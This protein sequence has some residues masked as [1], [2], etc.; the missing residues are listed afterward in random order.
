MDP[1]LFGQ[2]FSP[3]SVK[4]L[5][6]IT[7]LERERT[8]SDFEDTRELGFLADTEV[9]LTCWGAPPLDEVILD[10]AP[11]LRALVHAAGS[12]KEI[13]TDECWTRG[14]SVSS[15][16]WANARPVAEYTLGA[17][18]L[19]NKRLLELRERYAA[20]R[21]RWSRDQLPL[22]VGNYGRTIGIVGAS[23]V[24]RRLIELLRP[25]GFEILLCDPYVT[26]SE[27]SSLGVRLADLDELCMTSDVVSLHAP[28]LPATRHMIDGRRLGLLRDGATFINT[29]RGSLVDTEAL[30]DVLA[31]G[32]LYAVLDTTEPEVLP[33]D[34]PL[35]ELPNVV[36]TP[37][38]AGAVGNELRLLGDAALEELTRYASGASFAH[39]VLRQYLDRTA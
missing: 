3:A 11:N 29:A 7:Q 34:S 8:L 39:P 23:H 4:V 30:S 24:G 26:A 28:A 1:G 37:H 14:I 22:D 6:K 9:L 35:Y 12:V 13:V 33:D 15:A 16:A 10:A 38:I 32:R 21:S 20:K 27:A 5:A 31:T 36:L 2:L 25:F 18:L 19:S 17:I